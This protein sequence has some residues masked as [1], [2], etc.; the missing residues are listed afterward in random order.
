MPDEQPI[1]VAMSL[2]DFGDDPEDMRWAPQI[3]RE[4]EELLAHKLGVQPPEARLKVL[5]SARSILGKGV[6]PG[7]TGTETGLVVGYVQSGKTLSFMSVMALARDNSYPLIVLIAGSSTQLSD[8]SF[9]RLRDELRVSVNGRRPWALYPNPRAA[10]ATG[11]G[12]MLDQWRD[13]NVPPSQRKTVVLAIMKQFAN[14]RHLVRLLQQLPLEDVPTLI[15][16]DEADQASLN[17]LAQQ[18]ARLQQ[19]RNSTTYRRILEVRQAVGSH[20]FLQYTATPQ[21][22]LLISII[23][24]LSPNWVEVL[25]PGAGY[26]GGQTFFPSSTQA[27]AAQQN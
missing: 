17:T 14:L 21:A 5:A 23:D 10:D 24:T 11:I 27:S 7:E 8:Q 18:A 3:G 26:T 2:Q 20:T 9:K 13:P 16:D 25:A 12:G 19:N 4:V 6:P 22:P 15:I 1:A